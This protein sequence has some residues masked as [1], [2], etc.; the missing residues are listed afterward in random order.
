MRLHRGLLNGLCRLR[1]VLRRRV[2]LL[3][4]LLL[5]LLLLLMLGWGRLFEVSICEG[6]GSLDGTSMN[7]P[8]D[9]TS[10][11][12]GGGL[13]RIAGCDGSPEELH[14]L[15]AE[16][17]GLG[18]RED[19]T[20]ERVLRGLLTHHVRREQDTLQVQE[21][22]SVVPRLGE[23]RREQVCDELVIRRRRSAWV[24]ENRNCE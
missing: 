10:T 24:G 4:W 6:A 15:R 3:G 23:M 5:L 20:Q 1:V 17:R 8:S 9:S 2:D 7:G 11:N 12:D 13:T 19:L 21:C 16:P 18:Q 14:L 22:T